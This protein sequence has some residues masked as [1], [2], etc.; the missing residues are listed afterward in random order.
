MFSQEVINCLEQKVILLTNILN[1]TKQIEVRCSEPEVNLENLLEQ[2]EGFMQRCGK[3]DDLIRSLIA[4]LPADQQKTAQQIIL[5]QTIQNCGADEQ[6][7]LELV[8]ENE[9]LLQRA[10]LIDRAANEALKLQ[11]DDAKQHLKEL[12]KSG[13]RENLFLDHA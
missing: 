3:C 13:N 1:L 9:S 4:Q 10:A 5:N 11:Y 12:R 2:R 7:A 6:K 8:R